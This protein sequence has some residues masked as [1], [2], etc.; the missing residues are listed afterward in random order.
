MK[1][2]SNVILQTIKTLL[3]ANAW[4][5]T[6]F[7]SDKMVI[8]ATRRLYGRKF[9]KDRIEILLTIARPNYTNRE[10]IKACK[11][12]GEKLPVKKVQIKYVPKK[13]K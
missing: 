4:K 7:I 2:S 11:K 12:A 3:H 9:S 5:A 13:K 6:K 10:F 8:H 1:I